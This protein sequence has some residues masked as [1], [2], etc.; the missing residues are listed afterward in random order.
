MSAQCREIIAT[1]WYGSRT[2][3]SELGEGAGARL[4]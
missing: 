2:W 1:A 4:M 3:C